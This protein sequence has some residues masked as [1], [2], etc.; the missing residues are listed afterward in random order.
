MATA[1]GVLSNKGRA[2]YTE[3]GAAVVPTQVRS[4]AGS[5]P[6]Q[7]RFREAL[8]RLRNAEVTEDDWHL[9]MARTAGAAQRNG[10]DLTRFIEAIRL[11]P[12]VEK[13]AEYNLARLHHLNCPIAHIKAVHNCAV[14]KK[15]NEGEA[16]GLHCSV[17]LSE[18]ARVMLSC[19]P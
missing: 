2:M 1:N 9:F 16:G 15:A 6:A 17:F 3:F 18:G 12:T 19:N 14:A 4:Q 13:V 7:V 8:L 10:E 5:D 11:F